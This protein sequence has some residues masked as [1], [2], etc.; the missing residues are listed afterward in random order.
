MES[1]EGKEEERMKSE[2]LNSPINLAGDIYIFCH[3]TD[4]PKN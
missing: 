1:L 4:P 2:F 3:Y